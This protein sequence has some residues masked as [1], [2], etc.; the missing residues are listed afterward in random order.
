MDAEDFKLRTMKFGMA[1]MDLVEALPKR[2]ISE[3][4]GRQLVRAA[5][6]VGSH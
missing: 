4:L 6:S 3:V 2:M 1:V 5:A